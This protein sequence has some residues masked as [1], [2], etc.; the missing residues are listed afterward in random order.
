VELVPEGEFSSR[1]IPCE[2]GAEPPL[3]LFGLPI[4]FDEKLERAGRMIMPAGTHVDAVELD[5]LAWM[6][7]ERAQPVFNLGRPVS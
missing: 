1:F 4:F 6:N 7:A 5:T 2:A 3:A